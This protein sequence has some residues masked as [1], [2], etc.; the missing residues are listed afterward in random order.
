MHNYDKIATVLKTA[1]IMW[2]L[3]EDSFVMTYQQWV[4][5]EHLKYSKLKP[6]YKKDEKSCTTN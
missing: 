2:L 3:S 6:M 4:F 5:S 1:Q